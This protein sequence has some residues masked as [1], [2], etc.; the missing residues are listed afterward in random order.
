MFKPWP[1]DLKSGVLLCS[2]LM[3]SAHSGVT[4]VILTGPCGLDSGLLHLALAKICS[5]GSM[6][7]LRNVDVTCHAFKRYSHIS[8][9]SLVLLCD[10]II[11]TD[12]FLM[13]IYHCVF[14][15]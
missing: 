1:S 11:V 6:I 3:W 12:T 15:L 8:N 13:F 10:I 14:M 4:P 2:A 7:M 9:S 5:G